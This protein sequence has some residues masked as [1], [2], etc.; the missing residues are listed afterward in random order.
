MEQEKMA[1]FQ[2]PQRRYTTADQL[3]SL[4]S[5]TTKFSDV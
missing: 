3:R 2:S 5:R 1:F 4:R